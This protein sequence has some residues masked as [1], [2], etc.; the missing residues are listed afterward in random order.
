MFKGV[1]KLAQNAQYSQ[2]T[3]FF[4]QNSLTELSQLQP[5]GSFLRSLCRASGTGFGSRSRSSK[6][7]RLRSESCFNWTPQGL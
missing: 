4:L 6:R 7:S 3:V 5:I 2:K 1:A